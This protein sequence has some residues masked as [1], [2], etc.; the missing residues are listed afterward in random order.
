[1]LFSVLALLLF[2]DCDKKEIGNVPAT[3]TITAS[4]VNESVSPIGEIPNGRTE[5]LVPG[6]EHKIDVV[7]LVLNNE[8]DQTKSYMFENTGSASFT[9]II[10]SGTYT[11]SIEADGEFIFNE[12]LLF[13]GISNGVFLSDG[14]SHII[15]VTTKQALIIVSKNLVVGIPT[16]EVWG[17]GSE[18]YTVMDM[19]VDTDYFYMYVY[20]T[21]GYEIN[22]SSA[23]ADGVIQKQ[24][25]AG[26]IYRY[27]ISSSHIGIDDMF[28]EVIDNY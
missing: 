28:D 26:K 9:E 21:W 11:I 14:V 25:S 17:S 27:T 1:M 13:D 19:H 24:F 3:V 5:P 6:F 15:D 16:I 20:G 7:T 23:V 22:I 12:F 8:V 2:S 4:L 18:N 10:S